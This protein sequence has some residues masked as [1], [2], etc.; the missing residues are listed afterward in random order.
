MEEETAAV[1]TPFMADVGDSQAAS[2][3]QAPAVAAVLGNM[4]EDDDEEESGYTVEQLSAVVRP[5]ALTM[6]L[7]R[8]VGLQFWQRPFMLSLHVF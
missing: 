2:S 1:R 5:V 3:A 8:Y 4:D 6:I 7:A